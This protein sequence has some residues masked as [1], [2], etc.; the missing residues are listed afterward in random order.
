MTDSNGERT[1]EAGNDPRPFKKDTKNVPPL[2]WIIIAVLVVL[3]VIAVAKWRGTTTTPHG[4]TAPAAS[5]GDVIPPAT[6]TPGAPESITS[7]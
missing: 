7:G 6:S 2:V 3:A 1:K 4:G 5:S